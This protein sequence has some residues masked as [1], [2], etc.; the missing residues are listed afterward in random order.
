M[1]HIAAV[2]FTLLACPAF[3][4]WPMLG[5]DP[6]RS[7]AT[8]EEI[9]PPFERKWYREFLDEGI[10]AGVQPVVAGKRLVI[11]TLRG[12]VHCIDTGSG[13]DVWTHKAGGPVLH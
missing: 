11:G 8:A 7:G 1:R 6:G 12:V 10:N 3:A 4:D 5:H 9:R 13:K 2:L